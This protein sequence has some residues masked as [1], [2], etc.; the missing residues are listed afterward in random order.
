VVL[1]SSVLKVCPENCQKKPPEGG[2]VFKVLE[3]R[4]T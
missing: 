4:I 1:M 2:L 3:I